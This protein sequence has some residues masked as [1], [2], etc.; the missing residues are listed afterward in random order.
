[1]P[2][3]FNELVQSI[4]IGDLTPS[5]ILASGSPVFLD[6]KTNA[7]ILAINKLIEAY[8]RIHAPTYGSPIPVTSKAASVTGS[9][10]ILTVTGNQVALVQGVSMTNGGGAPII[11][12]V[13]I[14]S[15]IIGV[16]AVDPA[17]TISL[18]PTL[19]PSVYV[20]SANDLQVTVAS[21]TSSDLTTTAASILVVQ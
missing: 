2:S 18:I 10:T 8:G 13:K 12:H 7:D 19:I 4:N 17:S 14:G 20:D 9:E 21:G 6:I 11:A 16:I 5:Q 3:Q 1:M 15:S